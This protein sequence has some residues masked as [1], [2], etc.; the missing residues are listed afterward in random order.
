MKK[1]GANIFSGWLELFLF[2]SVS[3]FVIFIGQAASQSSHPTIQ[4]THRSNE[5]QIK[6]SS[7]QIR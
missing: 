1:T 3:L 6:M 5:L 2:A 7:G 4:P